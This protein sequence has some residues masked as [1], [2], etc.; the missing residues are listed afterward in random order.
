MEEALFGTVVESKGDWKKPQ[1]HTS[2]PEV[3]ANGNL[4]G[5][6]KPFGYVRCNSKPLGYEF[7]GDTYEIHLIETTNRDGQT[8]YYWTLG[9]Q[10][11]N[12]VK[13]AI[14]EAIKLGTVDMSKI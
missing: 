3:D 9:D 4:T 7:S 2:T 13:N 14:L 5:N 11:S 10:K 8:I 1:L 6:I 12:I